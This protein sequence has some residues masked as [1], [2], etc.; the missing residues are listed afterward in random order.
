[1]DE[2]SLLV[3]EGDNEAGIDISEMQSGVCI[4]QVITSTGKS[5]NVRVVKQ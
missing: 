2:H 5:K 1:M 3:Q 4:V